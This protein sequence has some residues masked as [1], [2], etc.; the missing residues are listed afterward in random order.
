MLPHRFFYLL[1]LC[2]MLPLAGCLNLKQPKNKIEYYTLEYGAP[3]VRNDPSLPGVIR[4]QPFSISPV[5]NSNRIIYRDGSFT[6]QAYSY[7]K[8]RANPAL[9]VT[10]YLSRDLKAS[11]LFKAVLPGDSRIAP[12]YLIEGTVDDFLEVDGEN[13]WEAALAVSI[14]LVDENQ[15]DMSQKILLQ[16][17]YHNRKPCEQKNPQSLAAAMSLAMA[18]IS[19]NII[20]DLYNKLKIQCVGK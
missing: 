12:A 5:Y 11:G 17:T 3:V 14:V 15:T 20:D 13:T 8:W 18:Q 6:R 19:G 9:L 10:Y 4:V 7:H 1:L 16:K 2:L